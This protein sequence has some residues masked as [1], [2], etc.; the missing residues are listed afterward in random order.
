L[1][2]KEIYKANI[3]KKEI[4]GKGA[5]RVLAQLDG[6]ARLTGEFM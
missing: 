3:Q 6:E 5:I 4:N 2:H 1:T